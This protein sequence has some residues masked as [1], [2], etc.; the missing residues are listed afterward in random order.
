MMRD[1]KNTADFCTGLVW[2]LAYT[3]GCIAL[4]DTPIPATKGRG[5]QL[6]ILYVAVSL[7]ASRL[8]SSFSR[9]TIETLIHTMIACEIEIHAVC[10]TNITLDAGDL[11]LQSSRQIVSPTPKLPRLSNVRGSRARALSLLHYSLYTWYHCSHFPATSTPD[12]AHY[13]T[14]S[15]PQP[16]PPSQWLPPSA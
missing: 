3:G 4:R 6:Y 12:C 14:P 2:V 5:A 1:V 16:A 8:S 15:H 7:V 11:Q 10:L 9:Q 13:Q